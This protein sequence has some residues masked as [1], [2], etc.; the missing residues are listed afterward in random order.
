[1]GFPLPKEFLIIESYRVCQIEQLSSDSVHG[2]NIICG[3]TMFS[4]K[5]GD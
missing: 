3:K 5:E 4:S 2:E 1:M